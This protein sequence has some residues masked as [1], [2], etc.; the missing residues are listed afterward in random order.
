M[1]YAIHKGSLQ[2]GPGMRT[3]VLFKGCSF[4][5]WW[6]PNPE[7]QSPAQELELT[8]GRC[9]RCGSCISNCTT[10][11]V[12]EDGASADA[13]HYSIN[14]EICI[15]CG[16]CISGCA[17][18][19]RE[20]A[21][22]CMTV[23]DVME[24]IAPDAPLLKQSGGGVTFSGGE[25]LLQSEFLN[26]LLEACKALGIHTMVDTSGYTPWAFLDQIRT[27]V[28]LFLFDLKLMDEERHWQFTGLPNSL[29]LEN[30]KMLAQMKHRIILRVPVIPG[31]NDDVE[32][33]NAVIQFAGQLAHLDQVILVPFQQ[34]A[35]ERYQRL[36]RP[37]SSAALQAP[38]Q[39]YM[40]DLRRRFQESGLSTTIFGADQ[41]AP[42]L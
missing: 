34:I 31:I 13:Q 2:D 12:Y 11:A 26:R 35:P 14:R 15:V 17:G 30:L 24:Q 29:I 28:D 39:A 36:G 19:A 16:A 18:H 33:M 25:P 10:Q 8:E 42:A 23:A 21:G 6:C 40:D 3:V 41:T 9:V 1:V 37:D 22:T 20:I 27:K 38:E 4:S 32:N 7:L 5:C